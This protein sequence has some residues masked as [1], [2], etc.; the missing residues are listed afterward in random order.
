MTSN[1]S[2]TIMS[3]DSVEL[4]ALIDWP[5][6]P[7]ML[8]VLCHPHPQHGGTMRAPL[9]EKISSVLV[10]SDI[11]VLRFNFRGIGTSTGEWHGG[12][13]EIEDVGA[14]VDAARGMET[15]LN[16]ALGGWSF[17][18]ATSLAWQSM[19]HEPMPW[20]GIA[21][22]VTSS[23]TPDLP[24]PDTVPQ[25]RRLFIVGDRDQ[26]VTVSELSDYAKAIGAEVE[27]FAGSDHFF[28]F[29]EEKVAN[30]ML[31]FLRN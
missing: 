13:G 31:E 21:P 14:A 12:S 3:T 24:L 27:V 17:G 23:R 8:L 4:E 29:R 30:R 9:L 16:L 6:D 28:H 18:A 2:F 7:R 20:I 15:R 1:E 10:G 11:A 22:P 5:Q 19:R 25:A 26:F